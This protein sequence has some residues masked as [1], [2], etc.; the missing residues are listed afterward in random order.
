[1]WRCNAVAFRFCS[2]DLSSG[3]STIHKSWF[4]WMCILQLLDFLKSYS[5]VASS[6]HSPLDTSKRIAEWVFLVSWVHLWLSF[7][8]A[9]E[10]YHLCPACIPCCWSVFRAA[11]LSVSM[12]IESL[13]HLF[14]CF[15]KM[16]RNFVSLPLLSLSMNYGFRSYW[17]KHTHVQHTTAE[18]QFPI[19][20]HLGYIHKQDGQTGFSALCF[21]KDFIVFPGLHTHALICPGRLSSVLQIWVLLKIIRHFS[22]SLHTYLQSLWYNLV[23]ASRKK[24]S[25]QSLVSVDS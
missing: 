8:V 23:A 10:P 17:W 11:F 20:H 22:T 9:G 16:W 2:L 5:K 18:T 4:L 15:P 24:N 6:T 1:M 21:A 14:T 7:P 12:L 3:S 25:W 13:Y 19:G